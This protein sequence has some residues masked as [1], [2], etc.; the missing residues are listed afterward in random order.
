MTKMALLFVFGCVLLSLLT[1]RM[2]KVQAEIASRPMHSFA[3]GIVTSIVGG[4]GA[5]VLIV[6]L[7]ISVIGIPVAI[8]TI[9]FA[10][11]ALYA[12]IAS[13]LATVGAGLVGHR[14]KNPHIHL[15]VGCGL[16]L[17]ASLV[18]W[19]GGIVTFAVVMIAVGVLVTTRGGARLAP[20]G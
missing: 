11:F 17:V 13:V 19:I 20:L 10:V 2:E 4:I 3:T 18:P 8:A 1:T 6:A 12:G 14:S 7:C 5:I 9:L 15:L 16:F